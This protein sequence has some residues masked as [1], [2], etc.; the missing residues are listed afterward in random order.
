L[1]NIRT[2]LVTAGNLMSAPFKA[3]IADKHEGMLTIDVST[4]SD[5]ELMEGTVMVAVEYSTLNYKDGLGLSG[6]APIFKSFPMV[7]GVDFSGEVITSQDNNYK[8]GD[9]VILNGWGVGESHFGGYAEHARVPGEWLVPLPEGLSTADAM[10]IGTAGYT[11]M[12]SVMALEAA[13]VKPDAGEILVTGAAG[14]VGSVAIALLAKL[15]YTVVASTGRMSEE[16]Y[17]KGLGASEIIDRELLST[18]PK[19]LAKSRWAGAIDVAGSVTLANI[20]SQMKY[21]GVVAA[22]GLAQGMDLPASVAPFILRGVKLIGIDSVMRPRDQR[23]KAWQRLAQ[24]LDMSK[25]ETMV[26]T[27]SLE[28]VPEYAAQIVEGKVKGRIVVKI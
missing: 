26:T 10:A 7:P 4:M 12:L 21:G 5:D 2:V 11:S 1:S 28:A 8:P 25:L 13:G 17:L 9:K 6:K 22:C 16:A 20:L 14:G 23:I 18:P 3:I 19:P 24:D 27:I 15:G